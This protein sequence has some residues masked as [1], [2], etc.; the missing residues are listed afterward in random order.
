VDAAAVVV[1]GLHA[2]YAGQ[3]ADHA[4]LHDVS[5]Q[6]APGERL[7]LVGPNGAGKST[8]IRILAGL[9]APGSGVAQILGRKPTLARALV[10]TVAHATFLYDELTALENLVLYADL[11]GV[12]QPRRRALELL[13]GLGLAFAADERVGNLSRGQQQRVA[14]A[15]AVVHDPPVL[16][17]DEPDTGLDQASLDRLEAVLLTPNRTVV[18]TTHNLATGLRFGTGA[19]V[20][21]H[22][23]VVQRLPRLAGEE[24]E[25]LA[26]TL[27]DLA[28]E[29]GV[30]AEV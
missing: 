14:L 29:R 13:D 27:R 1:Q 25:R 24:P 15:R 19:V 8:L 12:A 23:Q 7:L 2:R 18:L 11:Y 30:R 26:E 9:M 16:L 4:A 22:G 3:A 21:A 6:V 17:L 5:L 28:T 10:G 20:L